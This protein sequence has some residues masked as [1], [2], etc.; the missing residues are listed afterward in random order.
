V[1][2]IDPRQA[3]WDADYMRYWA[4]RVAESN[5]SAASAKS[6]VNAN[7]SATSSDRNYLDAI[8]LLDIR[9]ADTVLELGCGFGR[10]LPV[11]SALAGKVHGLDISPAMIEAAN[12]SHAGLG[13]VELHVGVGEKTPFTESMFDAIVCF[14]V[15]DAM[16]QAETLV[17]LNRIGE[18]GCRLLLTGKNDDY[19]DDDEQADIAE[20]R[21]R[22]KGHPNHFTN[23]RL[24]L[25]RLGEFGF[26]I[27]RQRFYPRRGDFHRQKFATDL[28]DLF[29]EYLLVLEKM[30][31]ASSG[32]TARISD[33]YSK[34]WRR[35]HGDA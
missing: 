32:A 4:E 28:P 13:N 11:L 8:G 34:T 26:R 18:P 29:Y 1:K 16:Y 24:L 21:A 7:D 12:K 9:R 30:S 22:E 33:P 19:F 15:F 27:R 20:R 35:K 14:A 5:T 25:S 2:D 31:P 17:E 3:Y 10:S 6:S 23:V